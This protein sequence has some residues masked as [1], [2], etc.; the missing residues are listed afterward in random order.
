MRDIAGPLGLI[1]SQFS[2][3]PAGCLQSAQA[4]FDV[5][6]ERQGEA[7]DDDVFSGYADRLGS[8]NDAMGYLH[9]GLG[10]SGDAFIIESKTDDRD[11]V[12]LDQW[13]HLV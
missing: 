7:I 10:V 1:D 9:P 3:D 13:E 5:R 12:L 2:L 6:P 11:S 4:R 8:F